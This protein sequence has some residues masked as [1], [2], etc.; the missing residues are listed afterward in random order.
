VRRDRSIFT[1]FALLFSVLS[2]RESRAELSES[3]FLSATPKP[4]SDEPRRALWRDEWRTFSP[5][6]GVATVAAGAGTAVLFMMTPP[7]DARWQGGILFDDALRDSMRLSSESGR[8]KARSLGDLPY[9]AAPVL[10]LIVDPLIAAYLAHGDGKAALNL[11]LIGLEAFSYS[12]FLSFVSTRS[13]ARERPDSAECRRQNPERDCSVDTEAF[14]SGHTSI[15][16]ASAGV[17]C[18]NHRAM[19]LWGHPVADAG[20]CA[21]ATTGAAFTGISRILADRHYTTDVIAGFGVGFGIGYAVPT[22]LHYSGNKK[23]PD[24]S[25]SV[26]PGAPC[27]GACVKLAGSF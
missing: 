20:A 2:T 18:A 3:P 6:E 4:F 7:T 5:W 22:L 11:E 16:A 13:S 26:A 24:V 1:I 8:R 15:A 25:L 17:T 19:P 14:W 21:L 9:Y 27:T 10:P 23:G 12:G